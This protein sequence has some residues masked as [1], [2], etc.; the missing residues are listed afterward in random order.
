MNNIGRM[1]M[2]QIEA[3]QYLTMVEQHKKLLCDCAA[4]S[5]TSEPVWTGRQLS[6]KLPK[7][8]L[9]G[10]GGRDRV[11]GGPS[12]NVQPAARVK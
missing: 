2:N 4:P 3:T 1:Q 7:Q 6:S 11:R 9:L 12:T 5:A 10:T 8:R